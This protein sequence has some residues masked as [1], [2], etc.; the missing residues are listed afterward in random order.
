VL[1][2]VASL[3]FISAVAVSSHSVAVQSCPV[4]WI[5]L[6][7]KLVLLSLS[8]C[9]LASSCVAILAYPRISVSIDFTCSE[10]LCSFRTLYMPL[11]MV[12]MGLEDWEG[13]A[14][15]G[16]DFSLLPGCTLLSLLSEARGSFWTLVCWLFPS[17]S[18]AGGGE[19]R[20]GCGVLV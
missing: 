6:S 7:S 5:M 4:A 2:T 1:V 9:W 16:A 10:R 18:G 15:L 14:G 12:N 20:E 19:G 17:A 3:A 13:R 8:A 11:A